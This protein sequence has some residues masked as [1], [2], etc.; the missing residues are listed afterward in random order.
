MNKTMWERVK[1]IHPYVNSCEISIDG[2][3]KETYETKTRIGGKWDVL[4]ENL[5]LSPVDTIKFLVLFVV[6]DSNFREI[7]KQFYDKFL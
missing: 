3:T 4:L 7:E 2:G 6:Q 5:G 1:A